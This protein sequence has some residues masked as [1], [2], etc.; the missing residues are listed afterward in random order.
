[1]NAYT[2]SGS[3]NENYAEE[4]QIRKKVYMIEFQ[5]VAP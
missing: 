3:L 4:P 5:V 1:M 2:G